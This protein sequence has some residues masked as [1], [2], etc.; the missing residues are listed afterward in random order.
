M[1]SA[2]LSTARFVYSDGLTTTVQPHASAGATFIA[3]VITGP[4]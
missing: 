1:T 4:L 3:N 2:S